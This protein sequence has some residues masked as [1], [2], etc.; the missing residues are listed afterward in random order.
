MLNVRDISC[1]C[2]VCEPTVRRWRREG[3]LKTTKIEFGSIGR[4]L[5]IE[6]EDFVDFYEKHYRIK[7]KEAIKDNNVENT[8][9]LKTMDISYVECPT[10]FMDYKLTDKML[11]TRRVFPCIRCGTVFKVRDEYSCE[12]E[13]GEGENNEE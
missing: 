8:D 13:N 12:D 9:G 2:G 11:R 4:P 3:K 10:C 6:D 5:M 7:V 1:M